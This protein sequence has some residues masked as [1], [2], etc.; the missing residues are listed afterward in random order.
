M[1][2]SYWIVTVAF[3]LTVL[4]AEV[5]GQAATEDEPRQEESA[6]D[7]NENRPDQNSQTVDLAPAL[8]GIETA[9]RNLVAEEDKI[10]AQRREDAEG[11]DLEAQEGMALWAEWMFYTSTA[12]VVLTLAALFAIVRT[13]HHTR[14]RGHSS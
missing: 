14:A 11:R 6:A 5:R 4:T 12:T 10:Q 7:T 13:L 8:K 9:I 1:L 2:K 3:G